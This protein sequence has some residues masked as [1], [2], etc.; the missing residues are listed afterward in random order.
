MIETD[1]KKD[2]FL[3]SQI[4]ISIQL[5]LTTSISSFFSY[6]VV[7]KSSHCHDHRAFLED[8][9]FIFFERSN[10]ILLAVLP[11]MVDFCYLRIF[12]IIVK[13]RHELCLDFVFCVA[14]EM[15]IVW[16]EVENLTS[17]DAFFLLVLSLA[18]HILWESLRLVNK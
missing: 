14:N 11:R 6:F 5:P 4:S 15:M 9:I 12:F 17:F 2:S 13:L 7:S 16:R 8:Y 18:K 10:F 1:L 3:S